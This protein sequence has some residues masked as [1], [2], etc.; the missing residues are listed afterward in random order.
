MTETSKNESD[1]ARS[2][3]DRAKDSLT[4]VLQAYQKA[5]KSGAG[6]SNVDLY[7]FPAMM[8]AIRDAE[9]EN[10]LSALNGE[11]LQR[12]E[13]SPE[14]TALT[15]SVA[16]AKAITRSHIYGVRLT[17]LDELER[18]GKDVATLRQAVAKD[19]GDHSD[20]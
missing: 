5:E 19:S 12:I 11:K 10:L 8:Y 3:F 6:V 2:T 18:E 16:G 1:H 14:F 4:K 20:T 13:D 15:R 17:L 7:E 9:R